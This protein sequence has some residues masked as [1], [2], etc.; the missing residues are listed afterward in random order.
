[1]LKWL[2][3]LV[4]TPLKTVVKLNLLARKEFANLSPAASRV[5]LSGVDIL[6]RLYGHGQGSPR[7]AQGKPIPWYSYPAIEALSALDFRQ[8][9]VFEYG[10]GG[11]TQWWS[12]R[13]HRVCSVESDPGWYSRVE[14]RLQ[15]NATIILRTEIGVYSRAVEEFDQEFDV[16]VVD[17]LGGNFARFEC[18]LHA[19]AYL[20]KGGLLILDNSDYLPRSCEMLRQRGLLQVDYDGL[21]PQNEVAGRTSFFYSLPFSIPRQAHRFALGGAATDWE[22][23][24]DPANTRSF[25]SLCEEAVC[26]RAVSP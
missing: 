3:D 11:S 2:K 23:D 5:A 9:Q 16:I 13:S 7:N 21:V 4:P 19:I 20:R 22:R 26:R 1:M 10:A 17:G 6:M 14:K 8:C 15:S 25:A 24:D 12:E 18:C